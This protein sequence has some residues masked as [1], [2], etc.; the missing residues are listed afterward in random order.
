MLDTT[1]TPNKT[2]WTRQGQAVVTWQGL[3]DLTEHEEERETP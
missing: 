1:H 2:T 3:D